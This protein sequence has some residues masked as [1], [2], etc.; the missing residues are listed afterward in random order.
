MAQEEQGIV[1]QA[2]ADIFQCID[3]KTGFLSYPKLLAFINT[4]LP[5]ATIANVVAQT[6]ENKCDMRSD[7][8][9]DSTT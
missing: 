4:Q 9:H 1:W 8:N 3:I 2:T 6:K 5:F 7:R